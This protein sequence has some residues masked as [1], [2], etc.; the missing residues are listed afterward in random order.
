MIRKLQHNVCLDPFSFQIN[1]DWPGYSLDLFSYPAHYSGD[2]D[3]VFIPHGVIMDRYNTKLTQILVMFELSRCLCCDA[4]RCCVSP[5][6]GLS[7]IWGI[8]GRIRG[9]SSVENL[10]GGMQLLGHTVSSRILTVKLNKDS[11]NKRKQLFLNH[12]KEFWVW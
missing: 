1:D 7:Q 2:L 4:L 6:R 5:A 9:T 10:F 3:C 12:Y 8:W 11:Q